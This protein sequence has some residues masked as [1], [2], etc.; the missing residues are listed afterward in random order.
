VQDCQI[1]I[2]SGGRMPPQQMVVVRADLADP[3]VMAD[4]VI[5]GLGERDAQEPENQDRDSRQPR[6]R[7]SCRPLQ[8]HARAL[9]KKGLPRA[10]RAQVL[11]FAA[12]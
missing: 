8:R 7:E 4:V 6:A 10:P 12:E 9:L 11:L 2:L 1:D 3:V 5:I